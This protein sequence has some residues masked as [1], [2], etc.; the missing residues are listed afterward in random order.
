MATSK[1]DWYVYILECEDGTL[2][3]GVA[4]DVER[5]FEEHESGMGAKYTRAH[6]AKKL[7]YVEKHATRSEAG[8]REVEIKSWPRGQKLHFLENI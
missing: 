3:T 7:L 2:Y 4:T 1:K 6:K 8:K 5:R